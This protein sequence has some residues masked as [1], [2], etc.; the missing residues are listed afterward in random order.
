VPEKDLGEKKEIKMGRLK[1]VLQILFALQMCFCLT[2]G[3]S[4]YEL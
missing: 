2:F 1:I 3:Q 4:E